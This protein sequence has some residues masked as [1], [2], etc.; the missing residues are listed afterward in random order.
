MEDAWPDNSEAV[1]SW[2][3]GMDVAVGP[4]KLVEVVLSPAVYGANLDGA[5]RPI[6]AGRLQ[7][8]KDNIGPDVTGSHWFV[9]KLNNIV[10][11]LDFL[12]YNTS[13]I[14]T[15]CLEKPLKCKK[16]EKFYGKSY[17]LGWSVEAFF[18]SGR[19]GQ[20]TKGQVWF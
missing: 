11:E 10:M 18:W 1:G 9:L 2:R 13:S 8:E 15:L 4:D 12:L 20:L 19:T 14:K 16:K 7:V 17:A 5:D 6:K 3:L